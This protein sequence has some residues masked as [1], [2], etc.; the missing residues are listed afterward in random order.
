MPTDPMIRQTHRSVWKF[1]LKITDYQTITA[2]LVDFLHVGHQND[3]YTGTPSLQLWAE[4][5]QTLPTRDWDIFI[6][7]TG[8]PMP[9]G[10]VDWLGTIVDDTTGLVWHVYTGLFYGT[11]DDANYIRARANKLS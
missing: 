2:P 9:Q 5:D 4:V 1:P 8:H 7:G 11:D 6:V 10:A 3:V